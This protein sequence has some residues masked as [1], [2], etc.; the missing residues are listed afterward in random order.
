MW[1]VLHILSHLILQQYSED[2]IN[3]L[4]IK[5]RKLSLREN[6]WQTQGH[7]ASMGVS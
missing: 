1:R 6:K 4:I 7:T 5:M 2:F 3:Y